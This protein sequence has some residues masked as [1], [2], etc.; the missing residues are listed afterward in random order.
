MA[1][2]RHSVDSTSTTESGAHGHS[3]YYRNKYTTTG[4]GDRQRSTGSGTLTLLEGGDRSKH[5]HNIPAHSTGASTKVD[6][7]YSTTSYNNMS[8][9]LSVYIW[10]RLG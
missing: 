8:P 10:R 2:H 9:Y 3:I 5:T 6:N 4:N 7:T 1:K